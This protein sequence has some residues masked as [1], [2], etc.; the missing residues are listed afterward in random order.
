MGKY[1]DIWTRVKGFEETKK[2][3]KKKSRDEK[4]K[5]VEV[6]TLNEE[7][8][9]SEIEEVEEISSFGSAIDYRI[10]KEYQAPLFVPGTPNM[11]HNGAWKKY[12]ERFGKY[13][14]FI[15]SVKYIRSSKYCTIL[16]LATTS[17]WLINIWGSEK[18]VSN[19][20]KELKAIGLL[21]DYNEYYQT[22]M[23]KLYCY[24]VENEKL[25][26]DHCSNLSISKIVSKNQQTLTPKQVKEYKKRC[27]EVYSEEFKKGV[28][29][30]SRLNLKR[31]SGV[32]PKQF[33]SDLYEMLYEN[34]P[35]F[36][37]YQ[38]IA[39]TINETYYKDQEEF[40]I[41][42]KPKFHWNENPKKE[43][44]KN[45]SAIVGIGIRASNKLCSA[46]K[47]DDYVDGESKKILREEVLAKYGF[48]FKKDITSSVPRV[49][50]AL[51][52][53]GWLK[54]EVDLY[55]KIYDEVEPEGS[56]EDFLV[57]REAIKKLFFRVYFDSTDNKLAFHT[58][59][60]MIQDG[61][62][63]DSVYENM[64]N[65][66]RAMEEILGRKRYDNYIFYVESCIYI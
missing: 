14:A 51:N 8:V 12:K 15:D 13:L 66:R 63:R 35:G 6:S 40:H 41:R 28:L 56:E 33:V 60:S 52:H 58:W 37:I 43:K 57:E 1:N 3:R 53:G 47:D 34:Y 23:C 32:K 31:P 17:Q 42:F 19:A 18:N 4:I 59:N 2:T 7:D 30:K 64:I 54:E 48:E 65:L 27:E 46:K 24:Y 20:I 39:E 5:E 25:L 26:I 38:S 44:D 16:A 61:I 21:K 10:I 11:S 45:Q 49:A 29:F 55:K 36:K 22:G 50:Y 62:D 9:F